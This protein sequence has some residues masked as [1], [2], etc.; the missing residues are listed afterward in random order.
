MAVHGARR[1]GDYRDSAFFDRHTGHFGHGEP[2]IR[3]VLEHLARDDEVQALALELLPSER[4]LWHEVDV[5]AL[6]DVEAYV[7]EIRGGKELSKSQRARPNVG[8]HVEDSD[9]LTSILREVE[10]PDRSHLLEGRFVHE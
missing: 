8:P 1:R 6:D 9:D 4:V 2:E 10:G 7:L 3:V 5:V